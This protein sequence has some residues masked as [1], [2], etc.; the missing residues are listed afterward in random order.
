MLPTFD[1]PQLVVN[2]SN[3]WRYIVNHV[4]QLVFFC[5]IRRSPAWVYDGR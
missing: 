5:K 3:N 4:N 2:I 1:A